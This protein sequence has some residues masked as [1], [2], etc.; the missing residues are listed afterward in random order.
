[1]KNK[2]PISRH[3]AQQLLHNP[4]ATNTDLSIREA[5]ER[6][7]DVSLPSLLDDWY[8]WHQDVNIRNYDLLWYLASEVSNEH[9]LTH[10]QAD[11]VVR[12]TLT[13]L[14]VDLR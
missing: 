8:G 9:D 1:M 3:K 10:N 7:M 5:V 14:G 2:K 12:H 6:G 11:A 4:V 13:S